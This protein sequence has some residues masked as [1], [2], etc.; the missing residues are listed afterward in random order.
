MGAM[1]AIYDD[2]G[3]V[4]LVKQKLYD[5]KCWTFPGGFIKSGETAH[6]A[7]IREVREEVN[8]QL[9][10]KES[11]EVAHYRQHW[12]NQIDVLFRTNLPVGASVGRFSRTEIED[13]QWFDIEEDQPRLN[14]EARVAY[15]VLKGDRPEYLPFFCWRRD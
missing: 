9:S 15:S 13:A 10:L 12:A 11:D 7:A 14:A 8:I 5:R 4:L 2:E 6:E 3:R 1:V